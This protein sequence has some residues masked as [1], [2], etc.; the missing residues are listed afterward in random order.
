MAISRPELQTFRPQVF[1][2]SPANG[3][4]ITAVEIIPGT[5]QNLF[6]DA[7][8][9]E[10]AAGSTKYRKV[11]YKNNAVSDDPLQNTKIYIE[12]PT[13]GDDMVYMFVG[14]NQDTQADLTG[15]E[16]RFGAGTLNADVLGGATSID[17]LVEDGSI[18]I[19]RNSEF[20]R[21]SDKP[22]LDGVGNSEI[23]QI[24]PVTAITELAGVVTVPL[25]TG[26][27]N[28]YLAATPTYVS[29]LVQAGTLE[30]TFD[31]FL[32]TSGLSGT[33]DEIAN[34]LPL[35]NRGTIE[36]E[37][38]LTFTNGTD[39]NAV[40][41]TVGALGPGSTGGDFSPNNPD[42]GVPYFTLLS[43]GFGGTYQ[44]GDTIVFQTH[45]A[46]A[47]IWHERI[48]PPGAAALGGN[49]VFAVMDGEA[50]P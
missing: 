2:D 49:N 5:N 34:P 33:Y 24:H 48:I 43:A 29:S 32:V 11:F 39:Y 1:D 6:P 35:S 20:I 44:A 28:P 23:V 27:V 21:I 25:A 45:P 9:T 4:R 30:P 38:T 7:G 12:F 15:S 31:N 46:A 47:A 14:T 40:G 16:D 50:T 26:L 17:V 10:R 13:P 18:D 36:Q 8:V 22:D 37:W 3:G 19:F 41:D 42:W